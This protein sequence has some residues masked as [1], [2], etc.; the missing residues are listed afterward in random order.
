MDD[1]QHLQQ[2]PLSRR[3]AHFDDRT[4]HI[5]H[6]IA[7]IPVL[8]RLPAR[9]SPR[10]RDRLPNSRWLALLWLVALGYFAFVGWELARGYEAA[11]RG[12]MPLYTDYTSLYAASLLV[13]TE[14]AE[15]LFRPHQMYRAN[16]ASAYAVYGDGISEA[17]ARKTGYAPWM[18]PPTFILFAIPLAYL[19]YLL[20]FFVWIAATSLPYLM[21][22][23]A[24]IRNRNAFPFALAAPPAL[25]NLAYGQTGFLSAGLIGLGLAQLPRRPVIAGICI[26]LA[27]VKPHLGVLIPLALAAGG[28]W[29]VF[30]SAAATV[31]GLV[32][33]SVAILGMDPWYGFIG[34]ALFHLDGFQAGAYTWNSMTSVLSTAYM[35][36]IELHHA[37]TLQHVTSAIVAL[38][39]TAVWRHGRSH[40]ETLGLQAAI[41]CLATPLAIPMVYLYDLAIIVPAAAWLWMDLRTRGAHGWEHLALILPLAALLPAFLIATHLGIQIGALCVATMLCLGLHRYRDAASATAATAKS[42]P[43]PVSPTSF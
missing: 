11:A 40:P 41:L 9:L 27:S 37:W 14:P 29:R 1:H 39:V 33:A 30:G 32:V 17:Q 3:P 34:T 42:P 5:H 20:S 15:N 22:M 7:A 28:H 6:R 12:E 43:R 4:D 19:P 10:R 13:R 23:R 36:G 18:Y 35:A 31:A 26:G 38:C 24:I 21:A 16:V 2:P 25:F 8:V